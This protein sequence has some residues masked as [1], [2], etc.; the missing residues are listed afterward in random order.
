MKRPDLEKLSKEQLAY[1][2][3]L[4]GRGIP[5]LQLSIANVC[6]VLADELECAVKGE[7][8]KLKILVGDEKIFERFLAI[9]KNKKDF[10]A[11]SFVETV[12]TT[13]TK[14]KKTN[15]QDFVIKPK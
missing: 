1:V 11:L 5:K 9:V 7:R 4:E 13:V 10:D 6:D 3:Y 8:E 14:K 2:E 15:I 12:E